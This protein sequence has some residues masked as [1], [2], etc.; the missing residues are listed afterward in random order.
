ML[1]VQNLSFSYGAH[2]VLRNLSF[3]LRKG[4]IGT[5]I[6]ASGSGKTTIFKLLTGMLTLQQGTIVFDGDSIPCGDGKASYMMQEDM[7]LP[8]RTVLK[9]LTLVAELKKCKCPKDEL[10][11][12]ALKLL[13][14]IGLEGCEEMY[15]DE[16]SGG[17][18]QRVS[19]AQ[20]LLHERPLLLLDEPFRSL[21]VAIREQM[22]SL[23]REVREK[24]GTTILLIT[25]DFR[26][27]LS[28]SDQIFLLADKHIVKSWQIEDQSRNN[29]HL[30]GVLQNELG[31]SLQKYT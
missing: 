31:V 11:G 17:M 6:G 30:S 1:E 5:L 25:H 13:Q 3:K 24:Y 7:L 20:A 23:L 9:N 10:Y 22:Y 4:E 8:W 19:L 26:D 21:D 16:L 15:P 14:E 12:Q 29:P 27:A 2:Q 18:R 28:L